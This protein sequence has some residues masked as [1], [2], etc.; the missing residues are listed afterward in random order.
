MFNNHILLENDIMNLHSLSKVLKCD[1]ILYDRNY[2]NQ[3]IGI[4][5]D[6]SYYQTISG[7][8]LD[9][10][11]NN[12]IVNVLDIKNMSKSPQPTN[13]FTDM[14]SVNYI[15]FR[16]DFCRGNITDDNIY[17]RDDNF[18]DN[19]GYKEL[20]ASSSTDGATCINL[21]NDWIYLS[22]SALPTNK[23]DKLI[24]TTYNIN[25]NYPYRIIR[26]TIMKPKGVI[27]DQYS[28]YLTN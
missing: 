15:K 26:L 19:I 25:D 20:M 24:L 6:F 12:I 18:Q 27:I 23:S 5:P 21:D 4:G 22:K 28:L 16:V 13:V 1:K 3:I 17:Y 9:L 2:I 14:E 7:F 10:T 8:D 11:N